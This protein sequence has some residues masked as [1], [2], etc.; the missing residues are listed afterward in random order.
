MRTARL[1]FGANHTG[2]TMRVAVLGAGTIAR[3]VLQ[4]WRRGGLPGVDIAGIAARAGSPR[5]AALAAELG[6]PSVVG[7]S[8]LLALRPEV[9]LEAAGHDA[10][11]EHLVGL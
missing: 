10:V 1:R 5:A 3:L 2:A 9:V 6:V 11:R 8:A 4:A 7:R